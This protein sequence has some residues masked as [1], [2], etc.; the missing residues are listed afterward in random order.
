VRN[1]LLMA[2]ILAAVFVHTAWAE[3]HHTLTVVSEGTAYLGEDTT[4]AEAKA[5]ALNNARR[6]ALEEA[7]GVTVS[8][9]SVLY[10]SSLISDLVVAATKGLIVDEK[11]LESRWDKAPDGRMA[12]YTKI[13]AHVMPLK[14]KER[15]SFKIK[16]ASV[17]RPDRKSE[18]ESPVFQDGDEVQ[19]KARASRDAYFRVFSIDQRGYV[20]QLY[21]NQYIEDEKYPKGTTFVFP[22]ESL[23][24]QGLKLRVSPLKGL[25]KSVESVL[26]LAVKDQVDFLEEG[27]DAPT[28]TDLMRALSGVD[29]SI[30]AEKTLGYEVRK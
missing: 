26:I 21:P 1:L 10:N 27:G 23:R 9:S 20:T 12:W 5:V 29:Q 3:D 4:P 14:Q 19:I 2:A 28:I 22:P 16:K 11:V 8:G 18:M 13:E 6:A 30:W 15:G 25:R 24:T 7:V 17:Q